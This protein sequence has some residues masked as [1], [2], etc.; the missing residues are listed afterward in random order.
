MIKVV[1]KDLEKS[2]LAR[3]AVEERFQEVME[4]FP[5]LSES[6]IVVTLSM[7][8][9]PRQEYGTFSSTL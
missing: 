7:E 3:E 2:D 6:R 5:A 1:F 9:S 8:N 4:R